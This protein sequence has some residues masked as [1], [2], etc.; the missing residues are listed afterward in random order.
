M[1]AFAA[2]EMEWSTAGGKRTPAGRALRRHLLPET[3]PDPGVRALAAEAL[4]KLGLGEAPALLLGTLEDPDPRVV[5]AACL[6][7]WRLSPPGMARRA[8]ELTR[9]DRP[10]LRWKATYA[11]MRLV[12]SRPSGRTP[13]PESRPLPPGLRERIRRRLQELADD[14]VAIVRLQALRALGDLP[15]EGA[16]E[17][18]IRH[19][20]DPDPRARIEALRSLARLGL[21]TP[22]VRPLLRDGSPQVVLAALRALGSCRDTLEALAA[23]RRH[24]RAPEVWVR[25]AALA[26]ACR[27]ARSRPARLVP[28]LRRGLLD[29]EWRVRVVAVEEALGVDSTGAVLESILPMTKRRWLREE[30]PRVLKAVVGPSLAAISEEAPSLQPGTPLREALEDWG[31]RRD[32]ILRTLAVSFL[33]ERYRVWRTEKAL[34]R[35]GEALALLRRA[36]GDPSPDVRVAALEAFAGIEA[37]RPEELRLLEDAS[38]DEDAL[39]AARARS[40]LR[41]MGRAVPWPAPRQGLLPALR[42]AL[43]YRRAR[44]VTEAGTL[45]LRLF[46]KRAPLTVRNFARLARSGFYD[47]L[48]WHRVVPDFV[49]QDGCP[50]GD[51]WGGPGHTIR[52]EI[53]TARY[54]SGALGMALAGKDTGGSQYFLTLSPQPHLDGGY[55]VFGRLVGGWEVLGRIRPG[56]RIL[57]VEVLRG[58]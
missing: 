51:G 14:P 13:V 48:A 20:R 43:G 38:R 23:A 40:L 34:G 28:L 25:E 57:R 29:P 18:L 27:L 58:R 1:A 36:L 7:L 21:E 8:L 31:R 5:E 3:E 42:E 2:G 52:C 24:L 46:P 39:V 32:P 44:I 22:E 19:L 56:D 45:E 47:G 15:G 30:D 50:R 17:T 11:L 55:T 6:S 10:A 41:E 26:S 9:T 35:A 33:A 16:H 12:G 54:G 37:P 53:N 49:V 4:A